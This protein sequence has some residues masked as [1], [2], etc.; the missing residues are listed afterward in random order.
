MQATTIYNRETQAVEV[1]T[2]RRQRE[3]IRIFHTGM[4]TN[5]ASNAMQTPHFFCYTQKKEKS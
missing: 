3:K 4:H 5:A 1:K 2:D